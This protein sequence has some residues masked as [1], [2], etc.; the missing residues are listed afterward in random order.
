[1]G[2]PTALREARL[3][4][5][6]TRQQLGGRVGY[7]PN[8]IGMIE[9]GERRL[10]PDVARATAR[11]LN[12]PRLYTELML[13]A[14]GGVG[15]RWFDGEGVDRHRMSRR[16][17]AIVEMAE[18]IAALEKARALVDESS[19]DRLSDLGRRELDSIMDEV[20]DAIDELWNLLGEYCEQYGRDFGEAWL[21]RDRELEAKRF[22]KQP[23]REVERHA[24]AA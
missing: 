2:I 23:G 1:M 17:G 13:D 19:A 5:G 20:P 6:L 8:M 16:S 21:Q 4:R 7:H 3:R 12:H 24:R 22:I 9:A 10:A 18:A 15:P 11:L 14:T